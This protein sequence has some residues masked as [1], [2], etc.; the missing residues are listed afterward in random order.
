MTSPQC[1]D[2]YRLYYVCHSFLCSDELISENSR[3]D[4]PRSI[5]G[6]RQP[7]TR[8]FMDDMTITSKSVPEERWMLED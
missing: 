5:S 7:P 2:S 3:E 6:I 1:W 8:A 4:E